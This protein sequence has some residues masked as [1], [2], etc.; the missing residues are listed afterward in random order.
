LSHKDVSSKGEADRISNV[1]KL[2]KINGIVKEGDIVIVVAAEE[3][4][5]SELGKAMTM[6]IASVI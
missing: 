4:V 1:L 2:A 5:A 3:R 6:R